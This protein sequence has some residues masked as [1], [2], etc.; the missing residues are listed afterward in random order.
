MAPTEPATGTLATGGEGEREEPSTNKTTDATTS[1][2]VEDND[3]LCHKLTEALA[4]IDKE[5]AVCMLNS[6][7]NGLVCN[8][9]AFSMKL[10]VLPCAHPPTV[11]MAIIDNQNQRMTLFDDVVMET[12]RIQ[13]QNYSIDVKFN[14]QEGQFGLEA[15]ILYKI[16][17]TI[18]I[19]IFEQISDA[20]TESLGNLFPHTTFSTDPSQ[21][22]ETVCETITTAITDSKSN[23]TACSPTSRCDG[24]VCLFTEGIKITM[25]AKIVEC[26]DPPAVQLIIDNPF[27]EKDR[28]LVNGLF[29]TTSKVNVFGYEILVTVHQLG[30][31]I[32]VEACH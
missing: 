19:V 23:D 10:W 5:E 4:T 26:H 7:C 27:S 8:Y 18:H 29:T 21:C 20:G 32:G 11:R 6:V 14:H 13:G 17:M 2:S 31:G 16:I 15:S 25:T 1:P 9:T 24:A 22:F 28:D 3:P 12:A 30:G